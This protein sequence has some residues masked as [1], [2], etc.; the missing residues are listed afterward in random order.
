MNYN[1]LLVEKLK[2]AEMFEH[3][4]IYRLL[5][6]N[7]TKS[8]KGSVILDRF[9]DDENIDSSVEAIASLL[10]S[11]GI[12]SADF[13]TLFFTNENVEILEKNILD[14]K[15]VAT[16]KDGTTNFVYKV[17][18]TTDTLRNLIFTFLR[19]LQYASETI[20]KYIM[21]DDIDE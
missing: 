4:A 13:I 10:Y 12:D 2:N 8:D 20:D 3:P 7:T 15:F 9:L 1:N 19:T 17:C 6:K 14:I 5:C 11:I 21:G 18:D 16:Y